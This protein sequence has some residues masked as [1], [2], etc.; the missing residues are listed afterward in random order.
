MGFTL[1]KIKFSFDKEKF[2]PWIKDIVI[3]LSIALA[4]IIA[5]VF[6]VGQLNS[7]TTTET[8][9][10]T[11]P[12][13]L[14]VAPIQQTK[15]TLSWSGFTKLERGLSLPIVTR[16][17]SVFDNFKAP[18]SGEIVSS[19]NHKSAVIVTNLGY[20]QSV[21]DAVLKDL[22]D[23]Y[24]I[25]INPLA[26]Y[27]DNL[28]KQARA[29]GH[30]IWLHAPARTNNDYQEAA[31][32]LDYKV[33]ATDNLAILAKNMAS[34]ADFVG[35][36]IAPDSRVLTSQNDMDPLISELS[37][38]GL[39]L[40][41]AQV[42]PSLSTMQSAEEFKLPLI[43]SA[44]NMDVLPLLPTVVQKLDERLEASSVQENMLVVIPTPNQKMIDEVENWL[45]LRVGKET[46]LVPP[47]ALAE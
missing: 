32:V 14:S 19:I 10:A 9:S 30:E 24:A 12:I 26:P 3:S 36:Y 22:P 41:T 38:R 6:G 42:T 20:D 31:T 28:L 43:A 21:I 5:F 23:E 25:A 4:C 17:G 18:I 15:E 37:R 11:A 27:A 44:V 13:N 1:P 34:L 47:S 29:K 46:N 2:M 45:S 39:G 16:K 8:I 33:P 35:V 40:I 7:D